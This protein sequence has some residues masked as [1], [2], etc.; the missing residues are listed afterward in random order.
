MRIVS[1][2]K[3]TVVV[4]LSSYSASCEIPP[5]ARAGGNA[6][7]GAVQPATSGRRLHCF[8]EGE[9]LLKR[10]ITQHG[11]PHRHTLLQ[12]SVADR[13]VEDSG[14]SRLVTELQAA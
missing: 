9:D 14:R 1:A 7:D 10:V 11:L 13:L 2:A 3:E 12:P 4:P 6:G 5:R 8:Q